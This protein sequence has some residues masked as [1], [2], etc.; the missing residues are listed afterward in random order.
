MRTRNM[1]PVL[2]GLVAGALLPVPAFAD[3]VVVVPGDAQGYY[4]SPTIG[5]GAAAG[6]TPAR[7]E[8]SGSH[9]SS[10]EDPAGIPGPPPGL[11]WSAPNGAPSWFT[12]APEFHFPDFSEPTTPSPARLAAQA[13]DQLQLPLPVPRH[14][15]DLRL[16]DGRAATLVGEHTWFWTEPSQWRPVHRRIQAGPAWVAVTATPQTLSL[17]P[18]TSQDPVSCP[19]PGT[20]YDRSFGL[21]TASPDCD[22]V[23]E[24]SSSGQPREQ[25]QA[26]WV[27]TWD[28][29]WRGF[30][31]TGPTGGTLPPMTS[32]AGAD[33][34]V[35]E[36]QALT[37]G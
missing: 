26:R 30:D 3:G 16:S 36:A 32:R 19:G 29:S 11:S 22:I 4:G 9:H 34:T 25:V 31:G 24:R 1:L 37:T 10:G 14:S 17:H 15:P 12:A 6:G 27:I 28:V 21:H 18:G 23:F 2:V 20:P 7:Q 8:G 33:L 5:L 13:A 35:A